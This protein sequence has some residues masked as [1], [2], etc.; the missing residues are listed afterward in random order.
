[1]KTLFTILI[2]IILLSAFVYA[3]IGPP[4]TL[5]T[6]RYK[7]GYQ[8]AGYDVQQTSDGGFIFTGPTTRY[9]QLLNDVYLVKTDADGDTI[10]TRTFGGNDS[11]TGYGIDITYDSGFIIVGN[12]WSF[13]IGGSDIY[14]IRTDSNGD[15]LW[16]RTLG[17]LENDYGYCVRQTDDDGYIITGY[18]VTLSPMVLYLILIKTDAEGD[19][20]WHYTDVGGTV[21]ASVEQTTDS[22]FI[23]AGG[24]TEFSQDD[25][26][27]YLLKM[28]ANGD[29]T[30]KKAYGGNGDDCAYDVEQTND[31]GYI[32]VGGIWNGG[33]GRGDIYL[34]KTDSNGDSIWTRFYGGID[35][36]NGYSVTQT[37]DGGY[38][39]TGRTQSFGAGHDDVYIIK[40]DSYGDTV[41]T[42]ILGGPE[43]DKGRCVQ[44]TFDGG[45]I[46]VGDSK[47]PGSPYADAWLIR[48][49]AEAGVENHPSTQPLKFTLHPPYPNPFN[50]RTVARFELR[51]ASYV[52][53]E[54]YDVWGRV[55]ENLV[56]GYYIPG[57]HRVWFDGGDLSSGVYLVRL[58]AGG[59]SQAQKILLLK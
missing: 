26:D 30:W 34:I 56:S 22:G 14:L 11:D 6:R 37:Q 35:D 19:T 49:A 7:D 24:T 8:A 54:V 47:P 44:Q 13:G 38:I 53:L 39:I 58:K 43:G 17:G 40:T 18:T 2:L 41:W 52:N 46:I 33:N 21:G 31:G 42:K 4:D 29:T 25:N 20:L 15:T 48:L 51:V 59:Y 27:V 16:T 10:W 1:M 9:G 55:V 3:Q 45:Y 57:A 23:V 36:E 28:N 5:W 50:Q 32:V 12:T